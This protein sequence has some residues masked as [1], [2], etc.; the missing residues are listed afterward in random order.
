[1]DTEVGPEHIGAATIWT[2]ETISGLNTEGEGIVIG[3]IDS[4]INHAHPSFAATDEASYTHQS[5]W[6]WRL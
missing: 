6:R 5:L 2:G 1:M 4:G 3:M